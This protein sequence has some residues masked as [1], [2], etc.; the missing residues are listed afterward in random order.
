MFYYFID[1]FSGRVDAVDMS[2]LWIGS[3]RYCG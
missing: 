3:L 1:S 2:D